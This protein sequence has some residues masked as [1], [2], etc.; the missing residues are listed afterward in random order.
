MATQVETIGIFEALDLARGAWLLGRIG[1][2]RWGHE[3]TFHAL[4][5]PEEPHTT[6]RLVFKDCRKIVWDAFGIEDETDENDI[7]QADVLG[8]DI[9]EP[10]HRKPAI[11]T[12]DL[13]EIAVS[14]GELLIEKTGKLTPVLQG[15]GTFS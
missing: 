14:Y 7:Q 12:T 4:Y 6:F 1:Q 8:M 15:T 11:I 2:R 10:Q 5:D 9:G 3:L 13:F